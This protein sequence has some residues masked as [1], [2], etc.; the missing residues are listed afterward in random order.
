MPGEGELKE[1]LDRCRGGGWGLTLVT[2]WLDDPSLERLLALLARVAVDEVVVNDFGLLE[3]LRSLPR[4]PRP[5][6]GRLLVRGAAGVV[7]PD[8]DP[9]ETRYLSAGNLHSPG[10]W[11]FVRESGFCRVETDHVG[12]APPG[13]G[14][15]P[16][17]LAWH[18]P[19][20]LV[21]VTGRCPWR[22][23]GKRWDR[24]PCARPC[25]EGALRLEG[26]EDGRL[27][28]MDGCGQ[29]LRGA[30]GAPPA[31]DRLVLR[32]IPGIPPEEVEG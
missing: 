10:W 24:G 11:E 32:R 28:L 2:S 26:R 22:F 18:A 20:G 30:A 12:G 17:P 29:Y 4:P 27:I 31:A 15:S 23:D 3:A 1:A 5:V 9:L 8:C 14:P 7:P 16:L 25:R 19:F 21:T 13:D 6:L